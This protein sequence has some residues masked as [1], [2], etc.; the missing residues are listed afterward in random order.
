MSASA[1]SVPPAGAP[2][3]VLLA[4]DDAVNQL[5]ATRLLQKR[6]HSVVVAGDGRQAIEAFARERFDLVLMDLHM[7]RVSGVEAAVAIRAAEAGTG[8]RVPIIAVT[9]NTKSQA[10][11]Q[12]FAADMDAYMSK[13][14][15]AAD[16]FEAIA[17]LL[18]SPA[19]HAP[20]AEPAA[21]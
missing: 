14:F 15:R 5:L 6:G 1:L 2:L 17:R 7:P 12:C 3:H 19:P 20:G 9:A 10:A 18:G 4:E 21:R 11:E 16:L 13:P 8:R